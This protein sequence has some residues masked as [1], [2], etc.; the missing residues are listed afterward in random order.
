MNFLTLKA[1]TGKSLIKLNLAAILIALSFSSSAQTRSYSLVYSDNIKG[2]STIL[3]NTLLHIITN[4]KVDTFKMNNNRNNGNSTYGNDDQDMEYIDIDGNKKDGKA[5][6]NSSSADL[7]LPSGTN[8]IKLARLYWGGRVRDWDFDLS[9]KEN[10]TIK[11]RKG[12]TDEYFDVTALGIDETPITG[13]NGYTEYQAYADITAFVK[14]NGAGTYE[15]G[16][17]PLSTG[18]ISNGG[19]H[20]GWSIVVVY[21]NASE[22]YKSVRVYDGFQQVYSSGNPTTTT[23]TLTGLDVPSGV[24]KAGDAKMGVVS[25]EGDANLTGDFLKINDN[26]F[27]NATNASDNPWNGTITDNG[28]HVTTKNPNYTNQMGIDI[29]MF[30]VGSGYGIAPNANSATLQFGTE[31]DQ[32]YPGVF[33]FSIK[34]KDPTITLDKTVTDANN[35]H[36]AESGE[37]LTYTLKGANN[38]VGNANYVIVADTLPSTVT[39]KP[40]TLKIISSPGISAGIQTDQSGDDLAEYISQNGVQSVSFR[41]GTG[42]SA[43]QGGTLASGESYEVQFQVTVNDPGKGVIVPSIMNIARVTSESDAGV[44]FVDD[45]TAIIN[46]EAG[47]LPVTLTR[48]SAKL[49]QSDEAQVDWTTSMEINCSRFILQRSY[50]GTVFTDVETIAGNGTTNLVHNYST[51]DDLNS[52]TANIVYYRLKQIDLDG[53]QYLSKIITIRVKASE[54]HTI[55]SPN[56]FSDYININT[57]WDNAENVT[58]N[59]FNVQGKIMVSKKVPLNKGN[60][61]IRIENLS[62]LPAGNYYLQM[63]SP[64][65][66]IIQKIAK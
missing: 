50:D 12:T 61:D 21:E 55:I 35:N 9:D 22:S 33:T 49:L 1:R 43:S 45:G 10:R 30:D 65:Q 17:V 20:G 8:T 60:N 64:H 31:A 51:I 18:S 37:T 34:M 57:Q 39:Y 58:I 28:K 66:K 14:N 29:D 3:G 48:F 23:V 47:P 46:P 53:K 38:G 27:S 4:N 42:A 2:G 44:K 11:I 32:Y 24:M 5:T 62:N 52:F 6:M 13:T 63:V 40:G 26:L 59:I 56:P 41:I 15:V 19:N 7:I 54:S 36:L 16:N 25:W